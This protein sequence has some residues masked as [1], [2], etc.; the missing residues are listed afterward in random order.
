MAATDPAVYH[1]AAAS[2]YLT[3]ERCYILELSNT[4][5]EPEL[6]VARARVTPGVTT[7]RHR[8]VNTVERY[9][10]QSG[11]GVI[12][13]DGLDEQTV[14]PGA[15]VVIPP[16]VPQAISNR[17]S[18]RPRIPVHL[19]P[20]FRMGKLRGARIAIVTSGVCLG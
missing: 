3:D 6:S 18:R 2:E 5:A 7:K 12:H 11:S 10:V 8:V 19:H 16:G 15:V 9:V 4:P 20:A 13:V 1:P 14:G 17:G